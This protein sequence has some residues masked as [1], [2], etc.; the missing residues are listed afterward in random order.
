MAQK[1]QQSGPYLKDPNLS[2]PTLLTECNSQG[3]EGRVSD[4]PR[5]AVWELWDFLAQIKQA[6]TCKDWLDYEEF[7]LSSQAGELTPQ[8]RQCGKVR[9]GSWSYNAYHSQP[10]MANEEGIRSSRVSHIRATLQ[11]QWIRSCYS[12]TTWLLLCTEVWPGVFG[13]CR[14]SLGEVM[15]G[16][17]MLTQPVLAGP[18]CLWLGMAAM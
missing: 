16:C 14:D 9:F 8:R 4:K 1:G 11:K 3:N 17:P 13:L 7:S 5:K 15:R 2:P 10:K 6:E 18:S 12:F